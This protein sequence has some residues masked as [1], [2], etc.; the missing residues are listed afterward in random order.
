LYPYL[1]VQVI[2]YKND[3]GKRQALLRKNCNF[4]FHSIVEEMKL[5]SL[6]IPN[7]V[8]GVVSYCHRERHKIRIDADFCL[9]LLFLMC[10]S[11]PQGSCPH[12]EWYRNKS[13]H[14]RVSA[15]QD[16]GNPPR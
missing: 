12:G 16:G 4:L 15:S 9:L 1:S 8:S 2:V 14:F 13:Q 5:F 11:N 6:E 10:G 7:Q 3:Q